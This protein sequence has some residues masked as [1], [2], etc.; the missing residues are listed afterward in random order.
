M[1][2]APARLAGLTDARARLAA[3]YDA[4]LVVWDPDDAVHRRRPT[5]SRTVTDHALRRAR[6]CAGACTATFAARARGLRRR[7]TS[8]RADRPRPAASGGR[9]SDTAACAAFTDLIDLAAD[10]RS[11]APCSAPRRLLRRRRRTCS[12]PGR[13]VFIEGKYTDRGKWMDGWESRRKRGPGHDWCVLRL[14]AARRGPRLRRRHRLL[15]RQ[16]ARRSR[17]SRASH[18]PRGTPLD[19]AAR[20]MDVDRAPAADRRCGP[21]R[22]TCSRST[23]ATPVTHVRLNIFPDGGVAR[24]RVYGESRR[25]GRPSS[26]PRRA[27]RAAASSISRRSSNGGSSLA[28]SDTFF[29]PLN[30]LMM[31]GRAENMGDGWETRRKRGARATTGS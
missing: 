15:R 9:V 27:A 25:L 22:R 17:R 21:T 11:A 4:D 3:G 13:G 10:R 14:G 28:C 26:T 1:C 7:R 12:S 30:N 23:P 31:P 24:L 20:R 8:G 18:A 29:G 6:R 19:G 2:A 5:R 16:L